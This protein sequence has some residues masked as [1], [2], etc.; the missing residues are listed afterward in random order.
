MSILG[1]LF[2]YKEQLLNMIFV[3]Y[4]LCVAALSLT[5]NVWKSQ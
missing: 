4:L 5:E 2:L 1:K 3:M